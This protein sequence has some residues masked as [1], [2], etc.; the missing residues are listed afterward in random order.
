MT[1]FL[2][3][4]FLVAAAGVAVALI[5][6]HHVPTFYWETL[7]LLT[8]TTGGLYYLLHTTR[9]EKP[10]LFVPVF[11]GTLVIKLV[12]TGGFLIFVM[13][14]D[15]AGAVSNAVSFLIFYVVFTVLEIT[16]LYAGTR[17]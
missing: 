10:D 11:L 13:L 7:V 3:V 5:G 4:L 6:L 16:F 17:R 2:I 1:R 15:P 12:A 8:V 14:E 9:K